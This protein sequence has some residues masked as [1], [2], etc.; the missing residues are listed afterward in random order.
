[1]SRQHVATDAIE[2]K[3][4]SCVFTLGSMYGFLDGTMGWDAS[5]V[6]AAIPS[7]VGFLG[8]ASIWKGTKSSGS[9]AD[10][11]TVPPPYQCSISA[12]AHSV[13]R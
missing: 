6:S 13:L 1:M 12:S 4:G 3:R 7:G 10:A 8:A 2:G 5:R 9:G 11:F